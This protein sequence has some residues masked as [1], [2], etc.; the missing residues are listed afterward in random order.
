[1]KFSSILLS[2]LLCSQFVLAQWS[3]LP[4]VEV[5]QEVLGGDILLIKMKEY[6]VI[7]GAESTALIKEL[8]IDSKKAFTRDIIMTRS[9]DQLVASYQP[10]EARPVTELII[11]RY[12][13][14][15]L[16]LNKKESLN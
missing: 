1:M 8:G 10:S 3:Q 14:V 5:N 6:V 4:A 13:N 16:K 15:L 12:L 2:C 9:V 7:T 11:N